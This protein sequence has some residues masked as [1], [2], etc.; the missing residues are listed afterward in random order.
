M[1]QHYAVEEVFEMAMQLERNGEAYYT[2]AAKHTNHDT[3]KK[4]LLEMAKWERRHEEFFKQMAADIPEPDQTEMVGHAGEAAAYLQSMVA[5]KVFQLHDQ[6]M[7][8]LTGQA[9]LAMI[10][11]LAIGMEKE[12]ILFYLGIREMLTKGK[13]KIDEIIREEM[14]HICIL[15][16]QS[17][18]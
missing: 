8:R 16:D 2:A 10:F 17:L 3:S 7:Q 11:D 13:D 12:A 6:A 18:K 1:P 15:T 4:L 9:T 5:G 14:R